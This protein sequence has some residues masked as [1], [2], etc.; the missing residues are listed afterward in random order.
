MVETLMARRGSFRRINT[1]NQE[2]MRVQDAVTESFNVLN[3][4][5]LTE[6]RLLT[7]IS[8]VSGS[9]TAVEHGLGRPVQGWLLADADTSAQVWRPVSAPVDAPNKLLFL[10]ASTSV[11]VSII[12][13]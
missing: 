10:Q 8:L 2:L 1:Q 5:L 12:V 13:F 4:A 11:T 7:G 6:A 9:P 3:A